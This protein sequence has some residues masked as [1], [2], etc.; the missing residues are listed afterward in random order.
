MQNLNNRA[1]TAKVK[2]TIPV[3]NAYSDT[4]QS[5]KNASVGEPKVQKIGNKVMPRPTY[6]SRISFNGG[7]LLANSVLKSTKQ[8]NS[9]KGPRRKQ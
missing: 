1:A 7:S 9:S 8:N 2:N 6:G 4:E 5:I 3:P